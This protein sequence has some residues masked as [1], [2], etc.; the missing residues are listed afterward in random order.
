MLSLMSPCRKRQARLHQLRPGRDD[1]DPRAGMDEDHSAAHRG[2]DRD[3]PGA[4]ERAGRENHLAGDDVLGSAAD[5][6]AGVHRR[7]DAN[8]LGPGVGALDRH[9]G[10]GAVRHRGA[11]HDP[12]RSAGPDGLGGA[13]ARRHVV[14]DGQLDRSIL[15]GQG[16]VGR[17][18][19]VPVHRR[20]VERGQRPG[21][22]DVRR[23]DAAV[24]G[25]QRELDRGQDRDPREDPAAVL[26]DAQHASDSRRP[27]RAGQRQGARST[28]FFA[29]S[30]PM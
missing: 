9:D 19:G 27:Q 13:V 12:H 25:G 23:E 16:D 6:G 2:Q 24:R 10:V 22:R 21:C 28:V 11:G 18:H 5:V 4:D 14:D 17:E 20:V 15:A 7:H 29:P 3:L 1:G 8:D 26:V 30:A